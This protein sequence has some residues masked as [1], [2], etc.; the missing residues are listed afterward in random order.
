MTLVLWIAVG[1]SLVLLLLIAVILGLIL[2]QRRRSHKQIAD[3]LDLLNDLVHKLMLC[4]MQLDSTLKKNLE[5]TK[6]SS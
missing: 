2:V 6:R 5:Q 1:M 3:R 4:R